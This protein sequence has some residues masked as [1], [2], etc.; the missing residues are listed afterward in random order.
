MG[1]V[2]QHLRSTHWFSLLVPALIG[3]PFLC[4]GFSEI[5]ETAKLV[6]AY[7]E[8]QGTVVGNDYRAFAEGGAAYVPL[9]E[10]QAA[11]GQV[12]RFTDSV[13]TIPPEFEQGEHVTVLYNPQ[14]PE[15]AR[16]STWK[17][18]WFAPT[19][20]TSIGLIPLLV[21]LAIAWLLNRRGSSPQ[22]VQV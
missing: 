20:I 16:L 14:D 11:D 13:G 9:V 1:R 4:I 8:A 10:F 19:L 7:A 6:E 2:V 3:G 21:G 5:R 15:N 17:R 12:V 18:I 22:S